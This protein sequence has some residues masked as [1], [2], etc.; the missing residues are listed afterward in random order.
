MNVQSSTVQRRA[1]SYLRDMFDNVSD[2]VCYYI[3]DVGFAFP[4]FVRNMCFTFP[5]KVFDN[6]SVNVSVTFPTRRCVPDGN[7]KETPNVSEAH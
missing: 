7:Y 3:S 1:G 6:I 4:P 2:N 5:P